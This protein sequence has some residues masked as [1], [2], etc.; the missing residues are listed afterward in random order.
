MN[1]M[2][3]NKAVA[4]VLVSGI[5]FFM[6][7]RV[8]HLLMPETHLAQSAIKIGTEAPAAASTAAA[9]VPFAT[10]IASADPAAGAAAFKSA[11]CVACHTANEGGKPGVGPNLYGVVGS[12]QA[13]RPGFAYSD[14]L[15]SKGGKWEL[16]ELNK[17]LTKPSAYAA[18]TKMSFAGLPDDKK[19]A[20]IIAYLNTMT[21]SPLPTK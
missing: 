5:T 10:L 13:G 4:A 18:G 21:A 15:K 14:A 16:A 20:D 8:A 12:V 3:V 11:G 6:A 2:L 19:R 9:V 17:W 7:G 1:T